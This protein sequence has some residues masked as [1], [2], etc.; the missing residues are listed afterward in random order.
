MEADFASSV[1]FFLSPR[2]CRGVLNVFCPES[3]FLMYSGLLS[4]PTSD[5]MRGE[6]YCPLQALVHHFCKSAMKLIENIISVLPG[7]HSECLLPAWLKQWH[8]FLWIVSKCLWCS[9]CLGS[10]RFP[11]LHLHNKDVLGM[12][13]LHGVH[14]PKGDGEEKCWRWQG[15][16]LCSKKAWMAPI[17]RSP[18]IVHLQAPEP[19]WEETR[20]YGCG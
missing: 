2:T 1:I 16:R 6:H 9:P 5:W 4:S 20:P 14:P 8:Y 7:A 19:P 18:P 3:K 17:Q 15:V 12:S 13:L 11:E 10:H